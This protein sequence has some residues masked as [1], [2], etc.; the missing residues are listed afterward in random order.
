MLKKFIYLIIVSEILVSGCLQGQ[1]SN[2]RSPFEEFYQTQ[3]LGIGYGRQINRLSD[4]WYDQVE[5][6]WHISKVDYN[7]FSPVLDL[8]LQSPQHKGLYLTYTNLWTS[9]FI[10]YQYM[11]GIENMELNQASDIYKKTF[12]SGPT[13]EIYAGLNIL[14]RHKVIVASG[15]NFSSYRMHANVYNYKGNYFGMGPFVNLDILFT[16]KALFRF[17]A[18]LWKSFTKPG[19]FLYLFPPL[20]HPGQLNPM[21]DKADHRPLVIKFSVEIVSRQGFFAGIDYRRFEV[22]EDSPLRM[23]IQ[24]GYRFWFGDKTD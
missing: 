15:V 6:V 4:S 3:K 21:N 14:N 19:N 17:N 16:E 9:D 12:S 18:H 7:Y 1:V 23:G 13:G 11:V 24:A 22:P 10:R 2:I 5:D 20:T 8:R